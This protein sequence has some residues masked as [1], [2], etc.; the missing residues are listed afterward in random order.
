MSNK[1]QEALDILCLDGIQFLDKAREFCHKHETSMKAILQ[2]LVD[3]ET[4]MKVING[5]Y[6]YP[7][8]NRTP[9]VKGFECPNCHQRLHSRYKRPYCAECGQKLDWGEYE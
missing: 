5:M 2:E 6:E 8:T 7:V 1:Y 3:K 9:F 4:P